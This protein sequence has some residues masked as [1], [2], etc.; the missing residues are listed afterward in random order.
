[1]VVDV[2]GGEEKSA[3]GVVE[4]TCIFLVEMVCRARRVGGVRE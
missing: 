1:M 4:Y 2:V 3:V